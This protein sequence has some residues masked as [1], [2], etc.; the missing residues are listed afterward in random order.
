M[1][2]S[3]VTD[4]DGV[5]IVIVTELLLDIVGELEFD[6]ENVGDRMVGVGERD[7]DPDFEVVWLSER[8]LDSVRDIDELGVLVP[9]EVVVTLGSSFDWDRE[10]ETE[11]VTDRLGDTDFVVDAGVEMVQTETVCDCVVEW[12]RGAVFDIGDN[13]TERVGFDEGDFVFVATVV[14]VLDTLLLVV[15]DFVTEISEL[16]LFVGVFVHD[17]SFDGV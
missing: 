10:S 1:D 11:A 14:K 5:P 15:M 2:L 3:L 17:R 7:N 12:L 6:C 4:L 9:V 13:V 16:L 8:S